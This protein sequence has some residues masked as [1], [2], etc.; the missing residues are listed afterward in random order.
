MAKRS[1]GRNRG[2]VDWPPPPGA[3]VLTK[4]D[5]LRRE[6]ASAIRLFI[7]GGDPVAIYVLVSAASAVMEPIGK[8]SLKD[9][10]RVLFLDH[11]KDEFRVDAEEVLDE[12]FNFMKHGA[13]DA[14][15]QLRRFNP[16]INEILLLMC[17]H[18]FK[19]IFGEYF[20][21]SN[22]YIALC[23]QTHPHLF[24][25]PELGS[26][27]L[28]TQAVLGLAETSKLDNESAARAI[29]KHDELRSLAA[30]C[31]VDIE[32]PLSQ[33]DVIA[34]AEEMDKRSRAPGVR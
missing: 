17:C 9:T 16:V 8:A 5:V 23:A 18:D 26:L 29:A 11:I 13:R 30:S 12:P 7:A 6:L 14:Q 25:N 19:N 21:E 22:I 28:V 2:N 31:N 15:A 1:R 24:R 32:R 4:K 10:W 3:L 27:P 33:S 34:L 20:L